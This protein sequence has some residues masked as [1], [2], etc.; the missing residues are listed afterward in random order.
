[1]IGSVWPTEPSRH[2]QGFRLSLLMPVDANGKLYGNPLVAADQLNAGVGQ[3]V[4]V[5][6]GAG[7]RN[8]IGAR[9]SVI[10]AAV[11]ALLS[12]RDFNIQ[13]S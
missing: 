2:L 3:V 5:T 1:M 11:V 8:A 10:D 13:L 7:A 12:D 9:D 4:L 6:T